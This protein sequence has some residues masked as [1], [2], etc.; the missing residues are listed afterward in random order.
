MNGYECWNIDDHTLEYLDGPHLYLVD[1]VTVPSVSECLSKRFGN[2]YA[3]VDRSILDRAAE[4]GTETHK[5]IEEW[6]KTGAESDL[7]EL[8][9]FK[10]LKKQFGFEVLDNE[11]PVIIFDEGVPVMAGRLDMV[12][13]IGEE[14]GIADIKRTSTLDK[15]RLAYQ[16]NLYRIGYRQ[17]Y[18]IEADFLRG[19]HLRDDVR[20]FVTVP[21]NEKK[22]LELM[23]EFLKGE[24]HGAV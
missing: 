19:I 14:W 20:K 9:N 5:A 6:C 13:Q 3:A 23:H 4:R 15:E 17:S 8:R 16:L 2:K 7:P 10:F 22:A 1:G 24:E 12:I 21:V 18:G 11:V